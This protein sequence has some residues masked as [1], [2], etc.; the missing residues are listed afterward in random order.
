MK[1]GPLTIRPQRIA[2][3]GGIAVLLILILNLNA[4]IE[5][6]ARLQ[7]EKATVS[8]RGTAVIVTRYA[9]ET[10][11]AFATSPVAVEEYAREQAHMIQPGDKPVVPLQQPGVTPTPQATPVPTF[12]D[13]TPWELWMT[14]LFGK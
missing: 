7:N 9:L 10:Q 11:Q 2:I 8:A 6:L 14:F 1:L 5:E 13:M 4:R 12:E 3:F